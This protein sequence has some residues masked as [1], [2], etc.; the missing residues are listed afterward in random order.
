MEFVALQ[1]ALSREP[2][3]LYALLFGSRARGTAHSGSDVD[4]ALGLDGPVSNR[5]LADLAGRIEVAAGAP[6]DLVLLDEVGPGVAYRV[7]R[8][9]ID[10]FIRDRPAYVQR[11]AQAIVDWFDWEPIE[12]RLSD[13]VLRRA[14]GR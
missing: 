11:K 12:R 3:V 7:F 1:D 14:L 13:G 5:D 6:V 4:V 9:G 8:D 2:R 10:L